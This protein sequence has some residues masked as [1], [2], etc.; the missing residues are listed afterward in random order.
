MKKFLIIF[1][2]SFTT[3]ALIFAFSGN[4]TPA[5]LSPELIEVYAKQK[6]EVQNIVQEIESSRQVF[7]I[8]KNCVDII[9]IKSLDQFV[10]LSSFSN[11]VVKE[12]FLMW[13]CILF[14][15]GLLALLLISCR[16]LSKKNNKSVI[17]NFVLSS[18]LLIFISA[19]ILFFV[20]FSRSYFTLAVSIGLLILFVILSNV[21]GGIRSTVKGPSLT[22]VITFSLVVFS[23]GLIAIDS[24][25]HLLRCCVQ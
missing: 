23:Y 15:S 22:K 20:K 18:S 8:P 16:V 12:S 2:L 7:F 21:Q 9:A 13:F 25:L 14:S 6:I 17:T 3:P 5:P 10:P 24:V 4:C 1:L 19:P 11:I